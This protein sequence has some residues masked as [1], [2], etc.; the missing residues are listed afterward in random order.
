L[1]VDP[2]A[3]VVQPVKPCPPHWPYLATE[4]PP[5][6]PPEGAAEEVLAGGGAA[7]DE[8]LVEVTRVVVTG[9]VECAGAL[10][11]VVGLEGVEPPDP[12]E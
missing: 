9:A 8:D 7:A 10:V 11:V 1:Q 12:Q 3:Q 5:V 4:Q 2:E 6:E